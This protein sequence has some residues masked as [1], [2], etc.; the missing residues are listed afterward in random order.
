MIVKTVKMSE[1]GQIAIPLEIREAIGLKRG[2]ELLLLQEGEKVF[3]EKATSALKDE[4][5]PLLKASEKT[6]KKLWDNK[7]DEVWNNV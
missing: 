2:D 6:L 5:E 3:I 7:F 1:K 4:F